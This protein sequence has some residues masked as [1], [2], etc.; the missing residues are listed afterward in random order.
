MKQAASSTATG[1]L[2]V[3]NI[4]LHK[5]RRRP[6]RLDDP[7][8]VDRLPPH[9]V[10]AEQSVLG[11]CLLD[12]MA[13]MSEAITILR[14]G[15]DCFYDLRHRVIWEHMLKLYERNTPW[16]VITICQALTDAHQLESVGGHA[17]I[18]SLPD[19]VGTAQLISYYLLIVRDKYVLRRAVQVCTEAVGKIY[20]HVGTA[21]EMIDEFERDA[22][23]VSA[24][25][26]A[27]HDCTIKESIHGAINEIE[28]MHANQGHLT[29][30]PTGFIDLDKMTSGFQKS[31]MIVIAARPSLGKTSLLGNIVEHVAIDL[32]LPV[33]VFSLEMTKQAMVMRMLCSRARLNLRNVRDGFMAERDFPRLTG[34]AGKMSLAPIYIDDTSGLSI[35]QLRARARRMQQQYGIK[36]FGIDYMQLLTAGASGKRFGNRQEEVSYISCGIK[37]L[38]KELDVPVIVLC[39]LNRDLDREKNRKP[40]L[41]DLRESGSIEQDADLV[42]MLYKTSAAD[43][44]D[45][46]EQDAISVNLCIAKQRQGPTGDVPLTF[47]RSY[48]RFESAARV[49]DDDVPK[50][51][52]NLP[53]A[54]P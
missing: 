29:G 45:E 46:A 42:G 9:S 24:N 41:S 26:D 3:D 27:A 10:E 16:D 2:S 34:A 30:I 51:Q 37:T 14:A 32:K 7:T 38:A 13:S 1:N 11:C 12:P 5:S 8:K 43:E 33:A 20:E 21:E 35:L 6:L 15:A 25:L 50:D 40:R 44:N 31:D 52:T 17:Y 4:D 47:L 49:S 28:A 54:D 19:A 36:L 23:S 22:L 18:S 48:T 39:Q 53:Y